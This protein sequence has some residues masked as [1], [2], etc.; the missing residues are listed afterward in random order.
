MGTPHKSA[1]PRRTVTLQP[2]YWAAYNE[3]VKPNRIGWY[4]ATRWLPDLKPL[5][6]AVVGVLRARCYHNSKTGELRNE[7][8]IDMEELAVAV[9]VSRT[10]LWREFRDNAAL[11]EF[12]RRQDQYVLRNKGP[13]RED[14][15][16]FVAMDDPIHPDD[17]ERYEA[18]RQAEAEGSRFPPAKVVRREPEAASPYMFQNET[19][20]GGEAPY[21]FQNETELFQNETEL[22][23]NETYTNKVSSSVPLGTKTTAALP[24]QPNGCPPG[25]EGA[26]G[27]ACALEAAWS[28]ALILL[29]GRVNKPTLEA[30]LRTLRL[31]C[32]EED[33]AL[34][35]TPHAATRDWLE[36][37]HL[38][39]IAEALSEV[40]QRPVEVRL[41]LLRE[42]QA[43]SAAQ[44]CREAHPEAA[45]PAE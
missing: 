30:H 36:K 19:Y 12:V 4:L 33:R 9:G 18:L 40:L 41:R 32:L 23:Q 22:F 42:L 14:S 24:P 25:G 20:R 5:G 26:E 35:L 27:D 38:P 37:R 39:V 15:I 17:L 31:A 2:Y 6:Y 44:L 10:T 8:R 1:P 45:P 29:A 28:Q 7:I 3:I 34:L 21:M 13:Q 16:Y 43:R 11:S